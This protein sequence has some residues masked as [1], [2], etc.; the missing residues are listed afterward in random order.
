M[1]II[2]KSTLDRQHGAVLIVG[3]TLMVVLVII[4]VVGAQSSIIQQKLAGN[5]RDSG[6]AFEGAEAGTRWSSAWLQ[7]LGKGTL[8]R[9]F[10]CHSNCNNISRVWG[11]GVYPAQPTPKDN[12]WEAA[13]EYGVDPAD[14]SNLSVD[15]PLVHSQPKFIME[16][17]Y[18]RRDDLAGEPQKGVA[19]YRVTARGVGARQNSTAIVRAVMAKR[20][21]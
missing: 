20:F 6:L 13:R 18:F 2:Q 15:L 1:N 16:Q 8:A 4:G 17:Q 10:P 12:L 9:P 5:F 14:D 7:S 21:E 11:V 3:L 19:F